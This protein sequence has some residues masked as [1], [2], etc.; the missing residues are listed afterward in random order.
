[1][2]NSYVITESTIHYV[3]GLL[4][5]YADKHPSKHHQDA[6]FEFRNL[7]NRLLETLEEPCR[8]NIHR[9]RLEG[10]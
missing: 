7:S 1:M 3:T 6:L 8:L 5:R 10:K 9:H 2:S 4:E